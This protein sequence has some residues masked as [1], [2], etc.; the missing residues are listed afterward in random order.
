VLCAGVVATVTHD[1]STRGVP[2]AGGQ[3]LRLVQRAP[4]QIDQAASVRMDMSLHISGDGVDGSVHVEA[5]FDPQSKVGEGSADAAGHTLRYMQSADT[6]YAP[7]AEGQTLIYSGK[8]YV[9]LT[10]SGGQSDQLTGSDGLGYLQLLAGAGGQV[11]R[12]ETSTIDGVH[13]TRYHV[14]VDVAAA[15]ARTPEQL[16]S[17]YADQLSTLGL[18]TIPLDVW[19]DDQGSPRQL[20]LSLTAQ[21][22]T[23]EILIHLTPSDKPVHVELPSADDVYMASSAQE[24]AAIAYGVN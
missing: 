5:E 18:T 20:K 24:F 11:L 23:A 22:T 12:Y 3:V 19:L 4:L 7:I 16:R 17:T 2:V 13:V 6:L 14:N 1:N 8:H 15:L 10:I 21:G 9:G